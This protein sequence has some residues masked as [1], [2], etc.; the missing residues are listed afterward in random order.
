MW[1]QGQARIA[2][3]CRGAWSRHGPLYGVAMRRRL[4]SLGT[5]APDGVSGPLASAPGRWSPTVLRAV[6]GRTVVALEGAGIGPQIE[7]YFGVK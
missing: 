6:S 3:P 1:R 2:G 4:V 5:A 7:T